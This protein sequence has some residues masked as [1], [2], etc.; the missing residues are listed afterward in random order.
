MSSGYSEVQSWL[1]TSDFFLWHPLK[2]I[3]AN[4]ALHELER[5]Q[6]EQPAEAGGAGDLVARQDN[7]LNRLKTHPVP[8]NWV[9]SCTFARNQWD[10]PLGQPGTTSITLQQNFRSFR[11]FC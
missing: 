4:S 2:Q 8:G 9:R 3:E 5:L 6:A 7:P 11:R 1:L 10:R